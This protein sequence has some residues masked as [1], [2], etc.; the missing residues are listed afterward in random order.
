MH[1]LD[2]GTTTQFLEDILEP[3]EQPDRLLQNLK[4]VGCPNIKRVVIPIVARHVHLPSLNLSLSVN[5]K[6]VDTACSNLIF[7]NL[8][9]CCALE[10]LKLDCPRLNNLFLQSCSIAEDIL[11]AA[12]S[13]YTT[14]ETLDVRCCPKIYPVS[15]GKLHSVCPGL[16]HINISLPVS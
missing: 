16:K 8:S 11:E 15:M 5:L 12:V 6:E 1:D 9:N 10:I 3:I 13:N 7:L 14:L 2:W 4:C